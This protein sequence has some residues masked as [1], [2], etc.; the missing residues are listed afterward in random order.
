MNMIKSATAI[1]IGLIFCT[2]T[3]RGAELQLLS[4][5]ELETMITQKSF[6]SDMILIDVRE[7]GEVADGVI[8]SEYCHPYHMSWY[9]NV[10]QQNYSK[11]PS[12][13]LIVVYCRSG[14]RSGQAGKFLIQ[15][16]FEKVASMSG[17]IISYPG[18]LMD[19]SAIKPLSDL[20]EPSYAAPVT[21]M[22][23]QQYTHIQT[24]HKMVT[25]PN[26]YFTLDGKALIKNAVRKPAPS[27]YLL[28]ETG[29]KTE[30]GIPG[31]HRM[32]VTG[33]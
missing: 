6:E 22:Q 28:E 2:G 8:A 5:T 15:N 26:N 16:G 1:I 13:L 17:G 21:V 7:D 11:L 25:V 4:P 30:G 24:F 9:G 19:A 14:S 27:V 3:T 33:R 23:R 12:E 10:I 29:T 31:F 20:P 18:D 32:V